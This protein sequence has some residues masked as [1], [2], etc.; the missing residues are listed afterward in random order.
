M[1]PRVAVHCRRVLTKEPQSER[2]ENT[3]KKRRRRSGDGWER[4]GKKYES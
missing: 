2:S 3:K 4:K 1:S